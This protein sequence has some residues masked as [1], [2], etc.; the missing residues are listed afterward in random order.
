MA[1]KK[2]TSYN[3]YWPFL[4]DLAGR[5]RHLDKGE[6][7]DRCG[8]DRQRYSDF[9]GGTPITARNFIKLIGGLHLTPES[10]VNLSNIKLSDAQMSDL[11]FERKVDAEREIIE[12]LL[13][14]P[15]EMAR[16]KE[17]ML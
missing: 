14:D 9:D 4:K 10:V 7:F 15:D 5:V 2:K 3:N 1:P 11:D 13:N 12:K 8:I 17:R 6:W 16:L